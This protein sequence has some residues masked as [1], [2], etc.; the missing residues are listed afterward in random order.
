MNCGT[1]QG[2][3][4]PL[5]VTPEPFQPQKVWMPGQ[6]PVVAQLALVAR[7]DPGGEAVAHVVAVADRRR[8]IAEAPH[9]QE[10][11]EELLLVEIVV[12]RQ[13]GDDRGRDVVAL[14]VDAA[15]ED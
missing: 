10:R 2:P 15:G 13:V 4:P 9:R 3:R 5:A 6:A 12:G 7:V 11:Q 1:Y 8:K 14:V